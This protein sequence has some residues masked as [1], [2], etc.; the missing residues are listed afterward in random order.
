VAKDVCIL[1]HTRK[2]NVAKSIGQFTET[3]KA[4]MP[5]L[6]VRGNGTVS[7]HILTVLT[8]EGV[9]RLLSASRSP[10]APQVLRWI[11]QQVEDICGS[12]PWDP[13]GSASAPATGASSSSRLGTP[14]PPL[15]LLQSPQSSTSS[16]SSSS[17]ASSSSPPLRSSADT[18]TVAALVDAV[19]QERAV[20]VEDRREEVEPAEGAR[21]G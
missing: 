4:R 7:T 11:T 10:L 14:H 19:S 8:V 1:I 21:T 13:P 15:V 12:N 9:H 17:S 16:S 18:S 3:Q 6:C 5:V 20:K 2:G